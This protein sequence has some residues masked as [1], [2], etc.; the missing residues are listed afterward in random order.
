MNWYV[1]AAKTN[2][3]A[4]NTLSKMTENHDKSRLAITR[5][6]KLIATN[7]HTRLRIGNYVVICELKPLVYHHELMTPCICKLSKRS[8][9]IKCRDPPKKGQSEKQSIKR[10]WDLNSQRMPFSSFKRLHRKHDQ[11]KERSLNRDYNTK[12]TFLC[13]RCSYM[14]TKFSN[15]IERI[16]LNK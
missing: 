16:I 13:K 5:P 8:R 1:A 3:D 9:K 10:Y 12:L 6:K 11:M 14:N 7:G 15:Q 2:E 4:A